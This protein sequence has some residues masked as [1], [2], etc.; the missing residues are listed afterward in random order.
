MDNDFIVCSLLQE[1]WESVRQKSTQ[2]M[3]YLNRRCLVYMPSRRKVGKSD[4]F[5]DFEFIRSNRSKLELF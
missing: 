3:A 1:T 5:S 2:T 4:I